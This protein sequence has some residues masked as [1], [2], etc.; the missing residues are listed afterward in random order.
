[1]KINFLGC[2]LWALFGMKALAQEALQVQPTIMVVP[3]A[4]EGQDIRTVLEDDF[5]LRIA[6]S[7]V[8]EAFDNRGFS[9]VDFVAKLKEAQVRQVF[10]ADNQTSVKQQIID[11]SGA[12]IYVE[13]E[14]HF[15]KSSTGN[16]VKIIITAYEASSALSLSNKTGDSGKRYTEDVAA[17]TEM[18][19]KPILDDFL[20]VMQAKFTEVIK[21]GR[22]V[23]IEISIS[24]DSPYNID[25]EVGEDGLPLGD[26]FELW[27]EQ[28]TMDLCQKSKSAD[29][30]QGGYYHMQGRTDLGINFD[31]VR[32]P[33]KIKQ[34]NGM[35]NYTTSKF[36]L[37]I[38]KYFQKLKVVDDPSAKMKI[39][40]DMRGGTILI[41]IK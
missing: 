15:Q 10:K 26:A 35:M 31:Q 30:C 32:I 8:K 19:I 36:S 40:R 24:Q 22:F 4:K 25:T 21:N 18:A 17:L 34:G 37:E 3:F 7:K 9:T 5:N 16:A 20:N 29:E 38:L 1:M 33:L 2:C 14:V 23:A 13:T 28:I 11:F 12:D 41:T 27:L 39:G 6:I